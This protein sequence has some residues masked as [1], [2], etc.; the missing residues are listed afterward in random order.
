MGLSARKLG[1][2]FNRIGDNVWI[3]RRG[4]SLPFSIHLTQVD[5]DSGVVSIFAKV[6]KFPKENVEGFFRFLLEI[7]YQGL[8]H[9]YFA[10]H[11]DEVVLK[12]TFPARDLKMPDLFA[13]VASLEKAWDQY[14]PELGRYGKIRK[15]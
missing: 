14:S 7:N 10:L 2:R 8:L 1:Y 4:G 5:E 3:L 9:G 11:R 15:Y 12:K 13:A 6:M